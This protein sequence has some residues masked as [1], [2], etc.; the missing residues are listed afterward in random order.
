MGIDLTP[1]LR[2]CRPTSAEGG[3]AMKYLLPAVAASILTIFALAPPGLGARAAGASN[4]PVTAN[5]EP[6][7]LTDQSIAIAQLTSGIQMAQGEPLP[8]QENADNPGDDGSS[9]DSDNQNADADQNGDPDS[10]SDADQNAQADDNAD[11]A[12]QDSGNAADTQADSGSA[13]D[14]NADNAAAAR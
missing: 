8:A 5:S 14:Q 12:D 7:N 3:F 1:R 2:T 11:N 10:N 4:S 9:A 6:S 13:D